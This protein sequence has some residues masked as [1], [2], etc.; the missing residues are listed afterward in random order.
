[1][2]AI[3]PREEAMDEA[4]TRDHIEAHAD[5]VVRGDMDTLVADFAEALRPEPVR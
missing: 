3:E 5:A 1:L 4:T 2:A